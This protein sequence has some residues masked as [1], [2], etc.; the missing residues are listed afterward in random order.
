MD[1]KK[2]TKEQ[3]LA[4]DTSGN[5]ILVSA[6]AGSGK[7]AVLVERVISKVIHSHIDIDRMLVV[8]FTNASA[9]ELKEKLLVAIYKAIDKDKNNTFLKKQLEYLNRAT[10]TTIHSFCLEVLR[11]NFYSLGIDPNVSICDD[12]M[13]KLLKAKAFNTELENEYTCYKEDTFGLYNILSLFNDKDEEFLE[14][15]LKIYTYIN[16]FEYPLEWLKDKINKYNIQ[17]LSID[18]YSLDFGKEIYNAVISDLS[19]IQEKIKKMVQEISGDGDFKKYIEMLNIDLENI[20]RCIKC[21]DNSWDSLFENLNMIEYERFP[22]NKVAND[23]LREKLKKFR[24]KVI[25]EEVSKI[26]S[27]IYAKSS[28]ILQDL[29]NTYK[30]LEYIYYFLEKC[31]STYNELKKESNYIDFSDIEHLALK[32][33][34]SKQ[35]VNDIYEYV[36]TEQANKYKEKFIEVYTDEYQDTS[37]VQEAILN[38][39]S[40]NNNRFMVGDIKQSIY[41]F[42]QAMPEIFNH[43]YLTYSTITSVDDKSS[44]GVK[45]ILAKNFRSRKNVIDSINYIFSQIM[46]NYIGDSDYLD[47]EKLEFGNDKYIENEENNYSTEIN[48]LDVKDIEVEDSE[49][50]DQQAEESDT[51]ALEYINE[52]KDFEIEAKYIAEKI[53]DLVNVNPFKVYNM[54]KKTFENA[55]Y[56][57]IVIL[58]RNI[59]DKGNILTT[60]LKNNNI[61]AF[62]DSNVNLFDND[63]VKLILSFLKVIDNPLQDIEIV[64]LMYSIV[65][66]F[67]LDEIYKIKSYSKKDYIYECLK[68]I[69][70][71]ENCEF[72]DKVNSFLSLINKFKEYSEIYNVAE[73]LARIYKETNL[74]NQVILFSK[75]NESKINL[76]SL[77]DVAVKFDSNGSIYSFILYIESLKEKSSGDTTTAKVIGENENVVRIMTIHKSKGLE[78]PIVILA[79][80]NVKYNIKDITSA[81]VLDHTLG[82]GINVV[83][84][85]LNITYP[86]VIKEGIKTSMIRSMKSEE[87]RMLY[88]ALTRAKEKL[89]IYSTMK[90]YDKKLASM[91]LIYKEGKIDT[92]LIKN[93]NT[94][95]DN[96]LMA[97]CKY[98]NDE[99]QESKLFQIN[100]VNVKSK[101]NINNII[102]SQKSNSNTI[103]SILSNEYDLRED[104]IKSEIEDKVN[105]LK[106]NI[107]YEYKYLDETLAS[108]R[109]SVSELKKHSH[110]EEDMT[111]SDVKI[112]KVPECL[113]N[114]EVKYTAVRKGTLIHFIL[115]HLDFENINTKQDLYNYIDNLVKQKVINL[116]DRKQI[117]VNVIYDFLNSKIGKEIKQSKQVKREIEFV[118]KNEKFSKSII[119]GVIDI[120]YKNEDN[121]YTLVDFKTDNL[122]NESEYIDRYK[123]QLDIYKEAIEKLTKISVSKVYIYSFKLGKEIEIYE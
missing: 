25:K 8:T 1:E 95:I 71:E 64:S 40:N 9:V 58:L 59:K 102:S 96:I 22:S 67:T 93:N 47:D 49:D 109:I 56:K 23:V 28:Y 69:V 94:Y 121:T 19:I 42:R 29:K 68:N 81:I 12:V 114:K 20:D 100:V 57:D 108:K 104:D 101:E 122:L 84:E 119:Q 123:L 83:D 106:N 4:I 32:V 6:S 98:I 52:L 45:I 65:G 39:V 33:L 17:D 113:E 10:I 116:N 24:D 41:K 21:S 16:S 70:N 60:I 3:K 111:V 97:L 86:S 61:Q 90:D 5:N 73:I 48:I 85:N 18:L 26:K 115:E 112:L 72:I 74:Y 37:F 79:G 120:Y 77:I 107:D 103:G 2:W 15:M 99:K 31:D 117:N 7:T 87:L 34:V 80:T 43:K 91:F 36:P 75:S 51:E 46:S 66:K 13:S 110:E 76:D 27:N 78:F 14:Y 53:N 88:V 44:D 30:Y 54:D 82:I 62:S 38:S 50:S 118:L 63:E 55:R 35:L 11:C 92:T 89:I 105:I